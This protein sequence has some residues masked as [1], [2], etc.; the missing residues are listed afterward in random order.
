MCLN[1]LILN[2][3]AAPDFDPGLA[4]KKRQRKVPR[5]LEK[6][7][8]L[9]TLSS[10]DTLNFCLLVS[11]LAGELFHG[12]FVF[13]LPEGALGARPAVKPG[14]QGIRDTSI[15][16]GQLYCVSTALGYP[17]E[18]CPTVHRMIVCQW[19]FCQSTSGM[20][21]GRVLSG[22]YF[23]WRVCTA[24]QHFIIAAELSAEG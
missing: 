20:F 15:F 8:G 14:F 23:P 7:A 2:L 11:G 16:T 9:H 5:G 13:W 17:C 24:G 21:R 3:L 1:C 6:G 10:N 4:Q 12:R 19:D 22:L 18:H